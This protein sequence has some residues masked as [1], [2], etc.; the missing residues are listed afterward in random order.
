MKKKRQRIRSFFSRF[1][2]LSLLK[3]LVGLFFILFL[4]LPLLSVFIVSF[5]GQPV[6]I[7]GSLVNMDILQTNIERLTN[8]SLEHYEKLVAG[9]TYYHA[10]KNSLMLSLGVSTFVILMCLP[11]AY[12]FARTTM[13]FKKVFAALCTLP[14]IVPTFIS[15]AGFIIMFGRTGW[16]T[17]LFQTLGGDG[18]IFN[19]YSMTGIVLVQIF[20]FFPFA[21]WPMVA[22]FKL[23]DIS[24][25]EASHNLGAKSWLTMAFITL[26]LA[27]PGIISSALLIFTVS[28]SDFGTPI[29]LAPDGLNLIVVEAYREI[30]GFFNWAG[31]SILTVV[32]VI[33]AA[34]FF[35]LQRLVTKGKNYGTLSG[36]PKQLKQNSNRWVTTSLAIYTG[37]V[38]LIPLLAVLSVGVQSFA[39]TWGADLLPRGFTLDHYQMI[40]SRSTNN[41]V[42]SIVLALGALV[43]SV[44]ISTLISYFVVRQNAVKLDFIS[45][46]PLIVPGIA[47]GIAFIQTFNTAPLKLT[48]T[49]VILIIAYAIRRMP[50]MIRSTM[51]TMMSIKPDIEEASIN[52]GASKLMSIMT[53]VGPLMLPGIA[54]GSILVF[55]TVI[56][57]TSVTILMAPSD[58]A[59]MSLVVFQNL[60]RGEVYTASAMA[61]LIIIIV[62]ILQFVA[63]KITKNSLY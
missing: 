41:I 38:V 52:L 47:L 2:S 1:D 53:V 54:A 21:L 18:T 34:F 49:A 24:L 63:N 39:T 40:F 20:F 8:A 37:I 11:I 48:G 14:I 36:K 56:K 42:N 17:T 32:M 25:E 59:P 50:Y 55:V 4:I 26:P 27:L 61:I 62:L 31:A 45:S 57:E 35:W 44:V 29:I 51:G 16:A 30:S 3:W 43:I 6:N 7:L 19:V 23:S 46:I 12:G 13:P 10:L 15:A 33:V 5:T 28:F 58:W 9:G 60:L 22:A